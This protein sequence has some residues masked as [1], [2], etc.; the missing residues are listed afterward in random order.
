MI[1]QDI[2]C[3]GQTSI[4]VSPGYRAGWY[5]GNASEIIRDVR[6]TNPGRVTSYP[7]WEFSRFNS[8]Y[9]GE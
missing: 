9:P 6:S 1:S 7:D 3:S 4:P 2:T 5:Y 8:V